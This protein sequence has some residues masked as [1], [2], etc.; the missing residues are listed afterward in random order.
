MKLGLENRRALVCGSS[1]GLGRAIAL[2]LVREGARVVICSRSADRLD[3][4][5]GEMLRELSGDAEPGATS[6]V[7]PSPDRIHTVVA[8]LSDPKGRQAAF[9]GAVDAF[10]GL[11]ILVTN[12]GGPPSGPFETHDLVTWRAAYEGLLESVIELTGLVL[13]GMKER[14]WGRIVNVTSISVKQPV[15]G[16]ILSN[17]LRAGVTGFARTVAN[18]VASHGITVNCVLPGYTRTERLG[19]LAA[20]G[21]ARSGKAPEEIYASWEAQTPAGRLGEPHELAALATFLCSERAGFIT[22]QSVA[23]D[24]GWVRSLV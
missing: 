20:A 3:R 11:D 7:P 10:E 23:V 12:T 1:S 2:E 15:E 14:R 18:E 6:Q 21:A 4:A 17:T 16:L 22:G 8:D 9:E 19:E 5:R 24:G 13:P